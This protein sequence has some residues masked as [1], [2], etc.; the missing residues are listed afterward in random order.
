MFSVMFVG[1]VDCGGWVPGWIQDMV[2]WR[3]QKKEKEKKEKQMVAWRQPLSL[4]TF[5]DQ[6]EEA[7]REG[8]RRFLEVRGFGP[9]DSA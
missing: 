8:G 4:G 7:A 6:F 5:R 9:D 1:C 3:Q 2:A